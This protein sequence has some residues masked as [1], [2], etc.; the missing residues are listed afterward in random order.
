MFL[1]ST[2]KSTVFFKSSE[3]RWKTDQLSY[4]VTDTRVVQLLTSHNNRVWE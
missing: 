3:F 4:T 2:K 1:K